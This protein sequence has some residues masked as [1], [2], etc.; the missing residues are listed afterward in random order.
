MVAWARSCRLSQ[1]AFFWEFGDSYIRN[2]GQHRADTMFPARS[3]VA[4]GVPVAGSSDAP[5][6]RQAPLF[7]IEQA[8]TRATTDGQVR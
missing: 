4:R 6:T 3:L 1:P 8:V 7:G 5:V 2:Y